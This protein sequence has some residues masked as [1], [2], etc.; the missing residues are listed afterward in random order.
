[1]TQR[2]LRSKK[3]VLI[4]NDWIWWERRW[5][6]NDEKDDEK[7]NVGLQLIVEFLIQLEG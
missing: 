7:E 6:E 1:M 2:N 4:A 5:E 3:K